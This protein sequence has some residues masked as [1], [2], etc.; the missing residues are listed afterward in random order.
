MTQHCKVEP[1]AAGAPP[2]AQDPRASMVI[3]DTDMY[4]HG[5]VPGRQCRAN[6]QRS[7][8]SA[9]ILTL[10]HKRRAIADI[11]RSSKSP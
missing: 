1:S 3:V 10:P 7:G 2:P 8:L 4:P 6:G 11:G 9:S 5:L